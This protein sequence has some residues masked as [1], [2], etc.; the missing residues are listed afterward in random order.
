[1]LIQ[2]I[3]IGFFFLCF[4]LIS[5]ECYKLMSCNLQ[6][7]IQ[8]N[9][10]VKHLMVFLYIYIFTFILDWYSLDKLVVNKIN[11]I[12]EKIEKH[13]QN[14]NDMNYNYLISSLYY[15][16]LIYFI[17][18]LSAK[19]EGI[20]LFIFIFGILILTFGIIITKSI[21]GEIFKLLINNSYFITNDIKQDIIYKYPEYTN[22]IN[23]ITLI[24]NIIILLFII[25]L[26]ILIIGTYKYYSRQYNDHH[27]NWSWIIFWLG[28]PKCNI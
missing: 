14:Y 3:T 26:I 13:I 4:V 11:N 27:K 23:K 25:L 18:L 15:S 17:F 2:K 21:N 6:K 8:N 7:Y 24:T 9:N 5:S 22:D 20:F 12:K 10:W 19:N 1:M 16:I 28:K